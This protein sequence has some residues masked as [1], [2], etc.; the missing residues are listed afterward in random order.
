[1]CCEL[2]NRYRD[3]YKTQSIVETE[4]KIVETEVKSIYLAHIYI[5]TQFRG[6]VQAL[7]QKV[8]G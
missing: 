8:A 7:Q 6:L 4:V 1:M 3:N 5:T 2:W